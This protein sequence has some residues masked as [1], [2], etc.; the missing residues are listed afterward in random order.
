[1]NH[2]NSEL[3]PLLVVRGAA[4]AIDFY[5]RALGASVRSRYEHG[6]DRHVSHAELAL[7][8]VCFAV[9]EELRSF[10]SDAPVSLGG[11]PVVLQLAV[12]DV[13]RA[14]ESMERAGATVVYPARVLLG[15]RMAR[16]RDP[17]G[18]LWIL[19]QQLEALSVAEIQR[20]RDE[21]FARFA[22][23]KDP[24]NVSEPPT[25]TQGPGRAAR[26]PTGEIYLV[27]G[28]VGAGKS[29][30]ALRLA[31]EC[32]GVRLTLDE[33]MTELFSPD[34]PETS[35]LEWYTERAARCC[36][37]IWRLARR[38]IERGT[39][40]V[41]EIGLLER[42]Q[43]ELFYA[44]FAEAGARVRIH[45]LDAAREVRRERVMARNR[46]RGATFSMHVPPAIFELASDRWEPLEP[47]ECSGR[48]VLF[49]R[50]D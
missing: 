29:T 35:V 48:D 31:E 49:V 7:G 45:V 22:A 21:L 2:S 9:T 20:E 36:S 14:L 30:H 28:P 34:R 37:Q 8:E 25:F 1:M 3:V 47:D 43:R 19:R 6:A 4:Q 10:N 24:T 32:G 46:E 13:E 38:L 42:G 26:S 39:N 5:V 40:V 16:V 12:S 50:T 33:W 15:E 11:S 17:F 27:L 23:P 41:L 44:R 18:H